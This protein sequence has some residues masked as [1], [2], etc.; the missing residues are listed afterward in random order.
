MTGSIPSLC[1]EKSALSRGSQPW[2]MNYIFSNSQ[3][4][5]SGGRRLG[6]EAE[7]EAARQT[8]ES[9]LAPAA[10]RQRLISLD[11]LCGFLLLAMASMGWGAPEVAKCFPDRPAW[12][13]AGAQ[14]SHVAWKGCN[15]WDL[16]QPA[17]M[18]MVGIS[19]V[20]SFAG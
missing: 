4:R 2:G 19:M 13:F 11:A 8:A 7:M 18:F 10:S 15:F 1:S 6:R 14:M 5:G 9:I 16:I 12:Q 20:Y 3:N 17:F